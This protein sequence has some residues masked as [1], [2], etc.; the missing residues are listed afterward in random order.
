MGS[1]VLKQIIIAIIL[2]SLTGCKQQIILSAKTTD[3]EYGIEKKNAIELLDIKDNV[4]VSANP[5]E[6]ETY[7]VGSVEVQYKVNNKDAGSIQYTVKDTQIPEVIITSSDIAVK[8]KDKPG[9]K[10]TVKD[11]IDGELK[12]VDKAPETIESDASKIGIADYYK[13]GWYTLDTSEVDYSK[14]GEYPVTL[15]ASDIHGNIVVVNYYLTVSEDGKNSN[16]SATMEVLTVDNQNF[17]VND[18]K[19][20]EVNKQINAINNDGVATYRENNKNHVSDK[21]NNQKITTDLSSEKEVNQDTQGTTTSDSKKDVTSSGNT[22]ESVND[23]SNKNTGPSAISKP[24]ISSSSKNNNSSSKQNCKMV[25][26]DAVTKVVHHDEVTQIVHH[27]ATGHYE[28]VVLQEAWTEPG[29][30]MCN[31]CGFKSTSDE[32]MGEHCADEGSTYTY[33][34]GTYHPA[35]TEQQWVEETPAW[36]ET[37]VVSPAWD[38]TV[39]VSQA[40]DEEVCN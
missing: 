15:T 8:T 9:S 38:E 16:N 33:V 2:G 35:I 3:I 18:V 32:E 7:K 28:T 13:E 24:N 29:Y 40:W 31:H 22:F 11:P 5:E 21:T 36:D 4:K 27:D 23:N 26:H 10:I 6:I 34:Y 25:H 39:V 1:N 30:Q 20:T 12:L 17:I 14:V 19:A 37:V